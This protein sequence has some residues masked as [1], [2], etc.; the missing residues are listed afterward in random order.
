MPLASAWVLATWLA[1][2]CQAA[3]ESSALELPADSLVPG[4]VV[5]LDLEETSASAPQVTYRDHR[6][7]VVQQGDRWRALVGIPLSAEPGRQVVRIGADDPPKYQAFTVEPKQYATQRLKVAPAQV[8]LSKA[9][10]ARVDRERV[11]IDAALETYS[12]LPP[13]TLQLQPPVDGARS[14]SFGLRRVFNEQPRSPH[15]GMDIAAPEGAPV[16]APAAGRVVD[17]GNYFFNGNTVF[18]DH[19]QGLV[20]MYCHLSAIDVKTGQAVSTGEPIGKVGKTGRATGPHLHF[21]VS[22]NRA[23]V[24]PALFLPQPVEESPAPAAPD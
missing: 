14:S 23:F 12:A 8:D 17:T 10:L 1:A 21:G 3:N 7:M 15:S 4:G 18:I 6:V 19:G 20:T 11:R 2:F 5:V 13:V 24:D 22:L 16:L 9:D